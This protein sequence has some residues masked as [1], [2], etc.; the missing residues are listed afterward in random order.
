MQALLR[1]SVPLYRCSAG[2]VTTSTAPGVQVYDTK[3]EGAYITAL[4]KQGGQAKAR[5]VGPGRSQTGNK[6]PATPA[7]ALDLLDQQMQRM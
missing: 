6:K 4:A 5:G 2:K 7:A 3:V 1:R